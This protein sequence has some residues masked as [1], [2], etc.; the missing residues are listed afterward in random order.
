[1]ASYTFWVTKSV[2]YKNIR[3]DWIEWTKREP[4]FDFTW[5]GWGAALDKNKKGM[6]NSFLEKV[7]YNSE[8][9]KSW[10]FYLMLYDICD[11][12]GDNPL[13]NKAK[14]AHYFG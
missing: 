7:P 11:R 8:K 2:E 9:Y 6:R 12:A 4:L 3:K 5:I 10:K 1:M 14:Q 13:P